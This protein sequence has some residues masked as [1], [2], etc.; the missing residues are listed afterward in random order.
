MELSKK[1]IH[2]IN[3]L[4]DKKEVK[5]SEVTESVLKRVDQVEPDIKAYLNIRTEEVRDSSEKLDNELEKRERQSLLEGISYGLKDNICTKGIKTTCASKMLDNFIPPYSAHVYELLMKE[6]GILLGKNNM[7]EFAMG[8]STETSFYQVTKNPWDLSRV[9]GGSS[10]GSA[11]SIASDTAFFALGTDTGGSLRQPASFC[12]VVGLKP[13]YGRVSRNGVIAFASSLDQ[14]GIVTKDV[15]DSAIVLSSISGYD[16]S[17]STSIKGQNE[18][19]RKNLRSGVKGMKIGVA[20]AFFAEGLQ[21][22]VRKSIEEAIK[23]YKDLGA[24][25]VDVSF[26]YLDYALASYY[27]ISSAEAS[28][29][30]ARYDGI[31]YGYRAEEYDGLLDLYMKSRSQGF[32]KEVK[33]RIM[34]GTHVL[35]TG[36]Y[37]AYYK[38]ATE[39][40]TLIKED[41]KKIFKSCDVLLT[42]TAPTTAFK[43]GREVTNLLEIYLNDIY[44][45]PA[46]LA[47]LP[48]MSIPCG[49]DNEG[50]PIGM[51]LLS[52]ILN[53]ET[54]LRAA[55]A[56][57]DASDYKTLKPS[58]RKEA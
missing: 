27:M 5:V 41:F 15:E 45:A 43:I 17:D 53:E 1:T 47:G 16:P 50:M 25:I 36:Y 54:L 26:E 8:S 42:P 32:G 39:I 44:T 11:A 14:V 2:E 58:F 20:P 28:S 6:N 37:D 12:G 57:E 48:G 9:P 40:R 21:S 18:D 33:R 49:L 30:M 10:G 29:N 3:D 19:F 35:S 23:L 13:T 31:C 52:N 22:E 55:W 7:D 51:Q 4:I 46:N 56:F 34:L 38:K 24:E